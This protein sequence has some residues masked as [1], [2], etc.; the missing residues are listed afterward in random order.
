M[1]QLHQIV[2]VVKEGKS[3]VARQLTDLYHQ[4]QKTTLFEGLERTYT[5]RVIDDPTSPMGVQ[6]PPEVKRVEASATDIVRVTQLLLT[7]HYNLIATQENANTLPGARADVVVDGVTLLHDL[8]AGTLL[9]L[10]KA[11]V[12]VRTFITKLPVLPTADSWVYD[13]ATDCFT[14][15]ADSLSTAKIQRPLVLYPATPEHPA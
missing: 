6:R 13:R 4:L 8:P 5:P 3:K 9:F 15:S 11:L 12:D 1:T 14:V 2:A 10:E 7:G